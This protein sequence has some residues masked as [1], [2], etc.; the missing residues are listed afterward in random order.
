MNLLASLLRTVVPL[1][2]GLLLGLAARAGFDIDEAAAATAVTAALTAGYYALF[3]AVEEWAAKQAH[4]VL[5]TLAGVLLG[6]ARPPEYPARARG[7]H[8]R[9][10]SVTPPGDRL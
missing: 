9:V 10:E 1:A 3:R 8:A 4:P 6:Y 2:V 5:R 7:V